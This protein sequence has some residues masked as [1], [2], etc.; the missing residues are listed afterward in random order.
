MIVESRFWAKVDK[1]GPVVPHVEGI[2]ECWVWTGS[3]NCGGYGTLSVD[4]RST[5]AHR[6]SWNLANGEIPGGQYVLHRC[7]NRSCVRPGHLFLGT[8]R[9]NA[10]DRKAK[11]RGGYLKGSSNGASVL[12]EAEVAMVKAALHAGVAPKDIANRIGVSRAAI[13][14]IRTGEN[15]SHVPWPDGACSAIDGR[16][17][18]AARWQKA[19]SAAKKEQSVAA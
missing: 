15:W 6:A 14:T 3:I 4:G 13:S 11:G 19:A 10:Q 17:A 2:D 18:R 7:D 8:Y 1:S 16:S 9:D 5:L 12:G